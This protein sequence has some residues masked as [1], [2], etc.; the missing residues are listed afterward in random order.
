MN[1]TRVSDLL[2]DELLCYTKLSETQLKHYYEPREGIFLCESAKVARRALDAGYEPLSALTEPG[3]TEQD[4][5]GVFSL[6]GERFPRIPVYEAP[7]EQMIR[8]TGY[9]LT[10]G[11]LLAMRRK[12]LPLPEELCRD[13]SRIAVLE[14]V[15]NPTNI[16]AVF[17]SAA[18]LGIEAVLLTGDCADPLYR[19]AA[20][21]SMGGVFQ[22]PWTVLDPGKET[23]EG[24]LKRIRAMGFHSAALAL[25]GRSVSISDP[26]L[27]RRERLAILLGNEGY[28]LSA[29][30]LEES[31]DIVKIPILP[32]VD[33]LNVAAA[34]AVA[35]WELGKRETD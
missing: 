17:R 18:A 24:Y 2:A 9:H 34:A 6:I 31:D 16:G 19:R 1:A 33:S 14:D 35:F 27:K 30:T 3:K 29:A 8:M 15:E 21:V 26:R 13:C 28:G 12:K 7:H 22:V 10:G 20:R 25:S 32:G 4:E 5:E 23:G 11:I